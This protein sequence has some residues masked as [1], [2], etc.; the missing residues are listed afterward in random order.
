MIDS[1]SFLKELYEGQEGYVVISPALIDESGNKGPSKFLESY[2]FKIDKSYEASMMIQKLKL[3][4][5][6][7]RFEAK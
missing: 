7:Y 5:H 6:V 3:K 4:H 2:S 1:T